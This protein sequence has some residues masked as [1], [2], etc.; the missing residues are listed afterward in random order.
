MRAKMQRIPLRPVAIGVFTRM[1]V[2]DN[3][4]KLPGK[5]WC[6]NHCVPQITLRLL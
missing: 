2:S 4:A 6:L 3:G 5:L 1:P